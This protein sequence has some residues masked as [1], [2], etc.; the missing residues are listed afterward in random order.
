[1]QC[2]RVFC[3]FALLIAGCSSKTPAQQSQAPA[4]QSEGQHDFD[5]LVGTWKSHVS[6]LVGPFTGSK[7][8]TEYNGI[9][10]SRPVWNGRAELTQLETD[11]PKGHIEALCLRLYNPQTHQWSLNYGHGNDGSMDPPLTGQ[12]KEGHGEFYGPDTWHGRP[13]FVRHVWSD[14]GPDTCHFEQAFSEDGGKTWEV[15]FIE[16]FTRIS[17]QADNGRGQKF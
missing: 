16:K 4:E 2:A 1:M 11:G 7:T 9:S 17:T 8:W 3:V 10:V 15:N 6:A 12:F 5:F 14:I 13:I